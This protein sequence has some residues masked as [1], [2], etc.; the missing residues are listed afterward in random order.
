M[1][2]LLIILLFVFLIGCIMLIYT[3]EFL[4]YGLEPEKEGVDFKYIFRVLPHIPKHVWNILWIRK[5]EFHKSL[6]MHTDLMLSLKER[7]RKSYIWNLE[8]RRLKSHNKSLKQE[9]EK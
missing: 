8:L 7:H 4:E 6:D 9:N 3:L 5:D 2:V 1:I